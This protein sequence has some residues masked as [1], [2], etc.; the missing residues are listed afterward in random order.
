ANVRE[1]AGWSRDGASA[2]PK[3]AALLAAAAEPMPA[4][5]VVSLESEGVILIYGRDE[6]AVE[7]ANLLKAHLDVTVL[8][9]PPAGL[10]PPRHTEFPVVRGV[11]RAASGHLG[12]F[13][14]TVDQFAQPLPSSRQALAFGDARNGAQSKCDAI[15]DLTGGAPLFP[16]PD[17]RDGYLRAD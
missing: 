15:L 9:K 10:Q 13:E 8:I 1:T 11:I 14:L 7:A 16:A 17:L 4:V 5:P 6:S 2:G 12:A 3:M